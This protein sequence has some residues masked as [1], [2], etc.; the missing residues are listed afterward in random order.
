MTDNTKLAVGDWIRIK[1][2]FECR[3]FKVVEFRQ[4]LGIWESGAHIEAGH[5][6]PLSEL[7][8]PGPESEK[9]YIPNYGEYS[10]NMVPSWMNIPAQEAPNDR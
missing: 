6:T 9:G 1:D 7:Y 3:D 4:C 8:E 2:R 10:T 5:F